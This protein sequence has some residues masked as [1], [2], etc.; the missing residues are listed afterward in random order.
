M[1]YQ[2]LEPI[3]EPTFDTVVPNFKTLLSSRT[4]NW[5]HIHVERYGLAPQPDPIS[6]PVTKAHVLTFVLKGTGEHR[7]VVD[8]RVVR[9]HVR[10][11]NVSL[12][13]YG[14]LR[15]ANWTA[16]AVVSRISLSPTLTTAIAADLSRAD[17]E[18]VEL[19]LDLLFYDPLI[20]Q[21]LLALT[22]ELETEGLH[23]NLYA[24]TLAQA[25]ALHLLRCHSTL[26]ITQNAPERGLTQ[27]QLKLVREFMGD[28][29]AR[30]ITLQELAA[31]V[32]DHSQ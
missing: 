3:P 20:E 27:P 28:H 18:Q 30:D 5:R 25:L 8:G 4:R 29:L 16:P 21:L 9:S 7:Y 26:R 13:P 24:D 12:L 23:G 22:G 10:P 6:V 17:P 31:L 14:T 11:G 32:L 2:T 19:A 15:T 1:S